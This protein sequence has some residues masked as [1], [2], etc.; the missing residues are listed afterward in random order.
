MRIHR[1]ILEEGDKTR[2]AVDVLDNFKEFF[3]GSHVLL[4][5]VTGSKVGILVELVL[6]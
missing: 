5:P 1:N 2:L 4:E 3:N 6:I